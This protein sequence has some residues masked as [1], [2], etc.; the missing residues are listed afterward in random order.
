VVMT[1]QVSVEVPDNF[2]KIQEQ[3]GQAAV[4]LDVLAKIVAD[5]YVSKA[6]GLFGGKRSW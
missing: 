1:F 6:V 3:L 5:D 2:P 4:P